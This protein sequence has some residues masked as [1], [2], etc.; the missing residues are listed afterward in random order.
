MRKS[1]LIILVACTPIWYWIIV[2]LI[3]KHYLDKATFHY[4]MGAMHYSYGFRDDGKLEGDKAE[5]YKQ[6]GNRTLLWL[7]KFVRPKQIK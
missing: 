5:V 3:T 1:T 4:Q 6:K 2:I 7:P